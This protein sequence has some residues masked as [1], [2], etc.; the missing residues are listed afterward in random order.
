[1]I[2]EGNEEAPLKIK[3]DRRRLDNGQGLFGSESED[4]APIYEAFPPRTSDANLAIKLTT[5]PQPAHLRRFSD[6]LPQ[7]TPPAQRMVT[8]PQQAN[9][10]RERGDTK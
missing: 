4:H 9:V 6:L 3:L 1:M 7:L 8:T 5:P 10:T 2:V